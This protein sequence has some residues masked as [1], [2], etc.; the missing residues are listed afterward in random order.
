MNIVSFYEEQNPKDI[1][2]NEVKQAIKDF[3]PEIQETDIRFLYH[4]S[5][6]VFEVS[7]E[8]IFR[9]PDRS[10][11]NQKGIQLIEKEIRILG[12]IKNLLAYSVPDPI[13]KRKEGHTPFMGYKK[14]PGVSLSKCFNDIQGDCK[15]KLAQYIGSFL[16]QLHSSEVLSA[17]NKLLHTDSSDFQILYKH[18]W[19]DEYRKIKSLILPRL[20]DNQTD[21]TSRIFDN[22]LSQIEKYS[23]K[24]VLTHGDF[25]ITNILVN[26]N[27]CE[28]TGI[29]DFED[30]RL[31][32]P[33]V[34]FLFYNEGRKFQQEIFKNY[35][36]TPDEYFHERRKFYYSRSCFPYMIFGIENNIPSLVEAGVELLGERMKRFP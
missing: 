28:L 27:S 22:F 13:F 35:S 31:F 14:I 8:Y 3:F 21:W 5:Y 30:A 10:L 23:F 20:D 29:I 12:I 24:P 16:S 11:R 4:G 9:I 34:D 1:R 7:R 25:D 26:P 15:Q 18:T 17:Y 2:I 32:D 6:N 19:N 36:Q 33:A